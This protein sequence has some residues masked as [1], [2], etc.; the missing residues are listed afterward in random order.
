MNKKIRLTRKIVMEY[1]PNPSNYPSGSN[2]ETM[3][4]IDVCSEDIELTFECGKII[5]DNTEYEIITE[6]MNTLR[7]LKEFKLDVHELLTRRY[8]ELES[9]RLK[10][11]SLELKAAQEEIESIKESLYLIEKNLVSE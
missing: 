2:I 5:S 6:D 3:A 7:K 9:Q 4:Q 10:G 1:I 8:C 11:D